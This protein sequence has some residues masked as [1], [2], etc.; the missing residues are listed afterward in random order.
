VL[1]E[2]IPRIQGDCGEGLADEEEKKSE[3][4][5]WMRVKQSEKS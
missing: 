3:R 1:R 5:G 2:N 4:E